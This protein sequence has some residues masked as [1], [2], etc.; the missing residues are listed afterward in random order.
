[1]KGSGKQ[2]LTVPL[3][4][5]G[6]YDLR[7]AKAAKGQRLFLFLKKHHT[8]LEIMY[9]STGEIPIVN[10]QVTLQLESYN[11]PYKRQYGKPFVPYSIK[12]PEFKAGIKKLV[13]CFKIAFD[14][15]SA[16]PRVSAFPRTVVPLCGAAEVNT[17]SSA[18]NFTGWL[19]RRIN[20]DY[21][22]AQ[23]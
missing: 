13:S 7:Y 11:Y 4:W 6:L 20:S 8:T 17:N 22:L 12:L 15:S 5:E 14:P 23:K 1:V 18:N 21:T 9:G 3:F 2:T 19:Y 10:E 16:F